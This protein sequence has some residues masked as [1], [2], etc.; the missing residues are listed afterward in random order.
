M[1][2]TPCSEGTF[3]PQDHEERWEWTGEKDYRRREV[4]YLEAEHSK[5]PQE[6]CAQ[7]ENPHHLYSR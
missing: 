7:K 5:P 2:I 6:I 3:V 4:I 1:H